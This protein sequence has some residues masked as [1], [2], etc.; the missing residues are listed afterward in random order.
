VA[1]A[2]PV[3]KDETNKSRRTRP[4][5][6]YLRDVLIDVNLFL[7]L[8]PSP[9]TIAIIASEIPAAIKP[10]SMAVAPD[11]SA[12]NLRIV[13]ITPMCRQKLKGLL[14]PILKSLGI[15]DRDARD[16]ALQMGQRAKAAPRGAW[17]IQ[18]IRCDSGGKGAWIIRLSPS[19]WL[20]DDTYHFTFSAHHF[21]I[22]SESNFSPFGPPTH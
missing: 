19:A 6:R 18:R 3:W 4:T 2:W 8:V 13:F 7:R 9:F 10:Y 14:N 11:S 1:R 22:A 15:S 17:Q 16:R 21:T 20:P 12:R 5:I